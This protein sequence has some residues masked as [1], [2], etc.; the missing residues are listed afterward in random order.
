RTHFAALRRAIQ[1]TRGEEVK[2]LGDGV[3]AIFGS[4]AD[5][6]ACA[7]AMQQAVQRQAVVAQAP[8]AIRIGIGLGDVNIEEGD[9][10]GTPVVE[11]ARLVDAA[12]PGQIL[13]TALVQVVAG[14]RAG[15]VRFA[16][17][18]PV[19][20]K[21]LPEPVPI[22]EVRW[23]ALPPAV[24]LPALLTD[25]GPVFVAREAEMGRLE[26]LWEEASAG[27]LRLALLAGEPGVGKTRLAA[28]LAGRVHD[29]GG[30]V[31][32]G[33]CDEDLGVP[34]QPFVE[35]LRHFVDHVPAEELAG[36]LGRYGGELVRLVPE[37][38]GRVPGL[39]APL[40]SDPETERYRLFDAVAAWLAAAS[41][42]AP[43][44]L[45]LD[46]LQ[47]AAGPTL[48]LLRHVVSRRAV[49]TRLLIVGTYRDTELGHDHP[50]VEVLADLR[51]QE[52]VERLPLTGLDQSG[53]TSLMEQRAGRAL[54]D[55]ELPLARAIYEETEGNPFF[56]REVLRN[57]AESGAVRRPGEQL[58]IPE[59]VREVVGRRLA[60]LSG[61]TN[62]VLRL[63]A[64]VGTEFEVPV[65]QE[66]EHL[67]EDE[68]VSALEEA[69]EARLVVGAPGDRYR[70]AHTLVRH[71]LYEGLSA[72]RRVRLHLRVGE[73]IETVHAERLDDYMP[74]LVH[75]WARAAAPREETARAVRYATRA[76]DL[77][78]AQLAHDEAVTYYRQGLDLLEAGGD[79][80]AQRARLL[81]SL[82]EAQHRMG[83]PGYRA[84]ILVA[85]QL[86]ER[87]GDADCLARAALAGYRGMWS[88]S[89]GVDRERVAAL[90]AALQAREGR[91]DLVRARLL[92]NLAVE[93]MFADRQRRWALSDEALAVA[94]RLGDRPTLGRV[95]LSRIA[96]IWEPGALAER[97]AHVGEL[98]ALAEDLGDPFVKVWAELY[99]FET[100]MEIGEVD[101][102]DR[103]LA[104][105]QRTASE[106]ER[107]LRWFAE[108]P[109]AGRA[110]FAGSVGEADVLARNALE[111]GR[112]T[113]PL[114]DF[115][116][117]YGVQR[118]EI[119]LEQDRADELLPALM[120][121]A[122]TGNSESRA[123]LAQAYCELGRLQDARGVFD[124]LMAV[125]PDV[126]PDP[127]WILAVI[128]AAS[129]CAELGDRA[130]A[131]RLYP[132][133]A[134]Y[135]DRIVGNGVVWIGS[136]AHY[137]GV[138]A[139]T[140]E[141]FDDAERYLVASDAAHERLHAPGWRARTRLAWARLLFR[142]AQ[143]KD[144]K[145]AR[146]LLGQVIA[147]ARELGLVNLERRAAELQ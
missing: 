128:R 45:V 138:L 47:W 84:T 16:D 27:D 63:A 68:L 61:N 29:L 123:M 32:A 46:D 87:L 67:D 125:L 93:L 124:A 140:L 20:L 112:A 79:D 35:A 31:L 130:A 133:L 102:A 136:V 88:M 109:R 71:T 34:Y 107:A 85:A 75:H 23:E 37:L 14:G 53:V 96:A 108:F 24:S 22:C 76:G 145:D 7:V 25:T 99:G 146:Q 51:R 89:L 9:V 52:G 70:F 91:E 41:G 121:A 86:A 54:A 122:G 144:A 62:Q 12:R 100:A 28:E 5:A 104:E 19:Q 137:L 116:M 141:R 30:T 21:G 26:Q 18:G 11:A 55:E 129:V 143:P 59:G 120:E 134:P 80:D 4:A 95:L 117:I 43:I 131:G 10:F 13:A 147:T 78:Q 73:A 8:L 113:E 119:R 81:V 111:I 115:R 139:T 40:R 114:Q 69:G 33:R 97:R 56:V 39:A 105:A 66:A 1:R 92:A 15:G 48:L 82:G 110:L 98:L 49:A 44:L 17:V 118:F 60:R 64:V 42:Q 50:L 94:R 3:L 74:A 57:L 77:A 58:E 6:V 135:A 126:P 127:N 132:L 106:V 2:T 142:R 83:D 90:E 101:E 36:R 103:M 72:A 38:A 65:L